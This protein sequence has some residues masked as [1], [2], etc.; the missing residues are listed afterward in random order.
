V[1][2]RI[3][4][5][6]AASMVVS[7]FLAGCSSKKT[8]GETTTNTPDQKQEIT[9]N[10]GEEPP[11]LDSAKATDA[12]SFDVLANTMEGLIRTGAGFKPLPGI[13]EKWDIS[14][15]GLVY[16]FN[17]RKNAKWSDGK[18]V[19]AKDFKFAWLRALDPKT[20]SE[21]A[22]QLYYIAGGEAFNTLDPKAKDFD[23]KYKE[24]ASKVAIVAPDEYTLKVTL[25]A[26][27]P[28]W[29][30]LMSFPTY[31][32]EREDIVQ[33]TGE[34]YAADA[35]KL[36]YNGPFVVQSWTHE[37]VIVL[38]KNASYWDAPAVKLDQVTWK[39]IKDSNTAIQLYE[40][41]DLDEVGI[42]GEFIAKYKDRGLQ[43][44]AQATTWYM[45]LN[46]QSK[47]FQSKNLRKALSLALDRQGFADSVLKNGSVPAEGLIPPSIAGEG[48]KSFR[49]LS[50]SLIP[51]TANNV[52]A[53]KYWDAALKEL[54]QS[55]MT[56]KF[57]IGDTTS[58]KRNAQGIQEMLQNSLPG[59]TVDLEPVSFKVR[60]DRT[61]SGQFDM[62]YAG[63]G[64]DYND[65]MTFMNMWTSTASYNDA[66]WSNK[67]YDDLIKL[68]E[69]DGNATSRMKAMADA[70]KILA[71][72]LP[73]IP[74]YHPTG[75]WVTKPYL[76]G[77]LNFPIGADVDLKG[78]F[79]EGKGK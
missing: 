20:G 19:T 76:K 48:G 14:K 34:K 30:G 24:L 40:A 60:L 43:S 49:Q 6:L 21:Y 29:L 13:A 41:G 4:T 39:M 56:L 45:T 3:A 31:L 46:L 26:P 7:A 16:T 52:E 74:L 51:S 35:D 50:G 57:L 9:L 28:F 72:E 25:A 73:I 15:D 8:G 59:L 5:V 55:K 70:E 27:T 67:Q 37:D 10:L 79:V 36:V 65:P 77:L 71:E 12:V 69:T 58:S 22:Y 61:K 23:T 75:N 62:V 18:P 33:A 68:A 2:K 78:A 66:K 38:K 64:A 42:P 63:W 54:G 44:M 47:T 11:N 17:L 53:K 32:P 1:K